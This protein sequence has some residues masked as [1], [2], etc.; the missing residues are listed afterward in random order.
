MRTLDQAINKM[1][2]RGGAGASLRKHL[3]AV[4]IEEW[5]D[6]TRSSLYEFRDELSGAVAP[7]TARTVCAYAK[8]LLN[9]YSDELDLPKD[10]EKILTVKNERPLRTYLTPAELKRFEA[11]ETR[12]LAERVVKFQSLVEAYTGAR[13]SDI[14]DFTSD[15]IVDGVLTYVSKKT[16]VRASVPVNEKVAWWIEY[17]QDHRD[18]E[19]CLMSRNRIIRRLAKKAGIT[20]TVVVYKA[21]KTEKGPKHDY[22]S[23]HSFRISFVTN[24]QKAGMDMISLARL[25]GHTNTGMTERYCAPTTPVLTKE[26]VAYLG[27]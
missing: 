17:A 13:V 24:L 12:N 10:W 7:S 19:P 9:R 20:D 6:I 5:K 25:A 3:A 18:A 11:V 21:G 8:A 14:M 23:S 26:A 27:C 16:G 1:E 4:G 22:I 2:N 15:N